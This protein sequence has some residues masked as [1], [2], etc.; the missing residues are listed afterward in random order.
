MILLAVGL[1]LTAA[2]M[3]GSWNVLLKVE[4]DPLQV[5]ARAIAI[6]NIAVAPVG[7]IAWLLLGRPGL[8]PHAYLLAAISGVAEVLYFLVLSKAYRRGDISEVYPTARGGAAAL[9][10]AA[11]I[12]ILHENLHSAEVL[13]VALLVAGMWFV[14]N[15][16]ASGR[17]TVPALLTAACIAAY[18]TLDAAGV[19][20][21]APWLYGWLL[22]IITGALLNVVVRVTASPAKQAVNLV[23]AR[24]ALIGV[25][26]SGA[27]LLVLF[28][29]NLAPLTIVAPVR[30]SATVGVAAWG[31]W[32]L[33]ERGARFRMFGAV[34]ILAGISAVALG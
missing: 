21:G 4:G 5:A 3:H 15:P 8:A 28:A 24:A 30:E 12:L 23:A 33:G 10:I 17:A 32:R 6:S 19:R 20:L 13:G 9:S 27:Y 25:L 16:F 18:S 1:A 7:L 34:L 29:L 11:G 14:R 22:W 2:V 31:V 26:M